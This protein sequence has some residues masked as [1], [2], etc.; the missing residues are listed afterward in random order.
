MLPF[1]AR[2]IGAVELGIIGLAQTFGLLIVLFIEFGSSL[3]ATRQVAR[4]KDDH[5]AL[6]KFVEELTLFKIYL[7]PIAFTGF[8]LSIIYVPIFNNNPYYLV[9]VFLGAISQGIS[10]VWYFQGIEKMKIIAFS[11][12]FFRLFGFILIIF[13]VKSPRD[14]WI[15]LA[16][17]SLSSFLICIFLFRE[18]TKKLGF[19]VLN[20]KIN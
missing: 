4:I 20:R 9:I 3:I 14:S 10:P 7:M 16:S 2:A 12:L 15:V 8:L 18:V 19:L 17:F 1:I 11:K 6:K 5:S 13:F